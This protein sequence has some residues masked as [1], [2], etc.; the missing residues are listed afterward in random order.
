M[1]EWLVPQASTYAAE[2][3]NLIT[4]ITVLVA[5]K[6]WPFRG[7]SRVRARSSSIRPSRST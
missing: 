2:I 1:I 6:M 5:S 7:R 3:D 4:L